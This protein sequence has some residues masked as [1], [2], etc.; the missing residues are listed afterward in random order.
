MRLARSIHNG[1]KHR[2]SSSL[3]KSFFGCLI[4]RILTKMFH[5]SPVL[6]LRF[7]LESPFEARF[8]SSLFFFVCLFKASLTARIIWGNNIMQWFALFQCLRHWQYA[9]LLFTA[10]RMFCFLNWI[11]W[12][13]L[14]FFVNFHLW[15]YSFWFRC[16][17]KVGH[18][19]VQLR[20]M[21]KSIVWIEIG[22]WKE[23]RKI[24]SL[25]IET[26]YH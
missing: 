21:R 4:P 20:V 16:Q 6:P 11:G 18:Y 26:S 23:N 9:C 2:F 15:L 14:R 19:N 10:R 17:L 8:E 5:A 1:W 24:G 25:Y 13:R 12:A 22:D 3:C 7:F